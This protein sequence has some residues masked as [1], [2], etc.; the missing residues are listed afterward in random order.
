[1]ARVNDAL[2]KA[3]DIGLRIAKNSLKDDNGFVSTVNAGRII[4]VM[5][6]FSVKND[7]T[8]RNADNNVYQFMYGDTGL[9]PAECVFD[10]GEP[11]ICNVG[12]MIDRLNMEVE[13]DEE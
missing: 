4:K 2:S 7:L 6:D 11:F 1:M 9:D 12:R 10:K 8:V 5:E 13:D 3:R